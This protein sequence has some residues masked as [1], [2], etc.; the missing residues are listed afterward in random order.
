MVLAM[1]RVSE[2][3]GAELDYWTA[4]AIGLERIPGEPAQF[5]Y[6]SDKDGDHSGTWS[7]STDWSQGGPLCEKYVTHLQ[8]W[9][10]GTWIAHYAS[11]DCGDEQPG[12][13]PLIAIC[14]AL[15]A[16]VYGDTVKE[17]GD[18]VEAD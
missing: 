8:L 5:R 15:V 9:A 14:R 1:R 17:R 4:E 10:N 16:S 7:P 12:P 13:T 3:E 11:G 6:W 18:E 2:L